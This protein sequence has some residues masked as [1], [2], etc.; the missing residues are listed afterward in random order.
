M[1]QVTAVG[2]VETHNLVARIEASHKYGRV[3]L[4]AGVRLHV[5]PRSPKKLL[6]AVDG[7]LL[8]LV[9]HFTTTVVAL[10][11]QALGV[12]VGQHAAGGFH[13]L[14][15]SKVFGGDQFDARLLPVQFLADEIEYLRI[16]GDL[17]KG[18]HVFNDE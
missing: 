9:H 11:G 15:R 4:R 1:R 8:D 7:E 5:G 13:H 12:F 17:G 14:L 16:A 18:V 2:K 6:R 10:A 3:G